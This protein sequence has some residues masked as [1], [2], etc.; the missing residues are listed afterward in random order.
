MMRKSTKEILAESFKELAEKKAADAITIREIVENCGFSPATFYRHFQNKYDLIAWDYIKSIRTIMKQIGKNGYTWKNV[1]VDGAAFF[2]SQKEY[3][4]NLLQNTNGLDS[5]VRRMTAINIELLKSEILK[6]SHE[7][8]LNDDLEIL[9]KIYC[10]G[11]VQIICDLLVG[12]VYMTPEHL[13][14]IFEKAVPEPLKPFLLK[15]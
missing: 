14:D 7:K 2:Y 8:I 1:L 10:H 5:F 11:I 3:I 6:G 12:N 4:K 15:N 9:V 13:G